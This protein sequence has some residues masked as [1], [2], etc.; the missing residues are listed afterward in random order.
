LYLLMILF[1]SFDQ[2]MPQ[3]ITQILHQEKLI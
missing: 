1:K 3:F 2:M